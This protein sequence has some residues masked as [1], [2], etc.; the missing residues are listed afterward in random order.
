[1]K[2]S[3]IAAIMVFACFSCAGKATLEPSA[4]GGVLVE[5]EAFMNPGGWVLDQQ[6]MDQ[7]GSP[8]LLAHGLGTPVA[9]A[10]TWVTFP[11]GGKYRVW[12]RTKDWTASW[13]VSGSP[14]RF[15]ILIDGEALAAEFGTNGAEWG[16]QDGGIV[17]ITRRTL[18]V[19]LHDL[20]GFEGRCDTI[21]F[22]AETDFTPP[23]GQ[24]ELKDFRKKLLGLP[25]EPDDAGTFDLVVAGGGMAGTC[26]ALAAARLGA[27][28][29][30]I[31]DRPVLGGNNS[32]EVRVW[33]G[34]KTTHQPYPRVGDIVREM[35]TKPPE[36]PAPA[37][38]YADDRKLDLVARE[39]NIALFLDY[40]VNEVAMDG[41]RI[42]ALIAQHTRTARR[43]RFNAR[44]FSDCT[45]D[46]CV[47][48]LAG[49]DSETT[50]DGHMGPTN[51]WRVKDVGSPSSF[52]PCPWAYD[53]SGKPFPEEPEK[54]G[55]WFWESGFFQDPIAD[56]ERI[57]DNNFR[58]MY[59]AWDAL[60]NAK[61][62]LPN[63]KLEWAAF[64]AGKRESRRLMG[65]VVLTKDD[66]MNSRAYDDGCV[67]TSWTIDLHLP[68][69]RY[70]SDFGK[71]AFISK[72][73][74]TQY[75]RPYWVPYRCL[76]SRNVPNLFMAGRNISV[77]H[78]ALGTVR[79]MRTTG[80]MGEIVGMAAAVCVRKNAD[81]RGVCA[82]HLDSLKELMKQGAGRNPPCEGLAPPEWLKDA[83][84]NLAMK[85]RVTTSGDRDPVGN[86]VSAINDARIDTMDEGGRWLSREGVPNWVEFA[87]DAP[88][89]LRAARII[90]GYRGESGA[91]SAAIQ[92]FE[93]QY[94]DGT[95]WRAIPE[96]VVE[97]NTANDW[98]AQFKPVKAARA[99]L[100]VRRVHGN[101]TRLW[102]AEIY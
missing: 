87:W 55:K 26:A 12:A 97:G 8:Y 31:Q 86:P 56:A 11:S 20:T 34:G 7:M 16:W 96:T 101:I 14:G 19:S 76:Y 58:A 102:E 37:A 52:P 64:V 50:L 9:D 89:T 71:D 66:L 42:A 75:P 46:A 67:P 90:S 74:F 62:K 72:A 70:E 13:K 47:G 60:K 38:A 93:L 21:L 44:L 57:R 29:A 32:S 25:D 92:D 5:A 30:L 84:P 36:C 88:Q 2:T 45:G 100:L 27:R 18:P 61:G 59:G 80:M 78:E 23:N 77:T 53:L 4:T 10:V 35:D 17:E 39:R 28:V 41:G 22:T 85:A 40:R 1:M 49:A 91:L 83:G 98:S 63:H 43:L 51:L 69:A 79:V 94:H 81:P 6:F 95:E 82:D 65:D 24:A 73:D 54:L 15:Q 33:L 68:D 99:R 3:A 48:F